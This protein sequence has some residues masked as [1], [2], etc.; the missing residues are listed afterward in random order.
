[1]TD[2][3]SARLAELQ[4]AATPG[5][6]VFDEREWR[7]TGE[8]DHRCLSDPHNQT[9]AELIVA[10]V[11]ALPSLVALVA[12]TE[13]RASVTFTNPEREGGPDHQWSGPELL[14]AIAAY[15]DR[16]DDRDDAES[17]TTGRIADRTAQADLRRWAADLTAALAALNAELARP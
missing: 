16:Q 17:E 5:P 3:A 10:L 14:L 15:M 11:N 6:W 9:D 13:F 4:A 1:M 12:A 2:T 7:I 8:Q